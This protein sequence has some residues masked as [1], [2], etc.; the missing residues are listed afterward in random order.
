MK[1]SDPITIC[2]PRIVWTE[3]YYAAVRGY[4]D[5]SEENYQLERALMAIE[6]Q[7]EPTAFDE[8]VN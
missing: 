5:D 3:L 6:R 4:A 8:L 7:I 1:P 2:L